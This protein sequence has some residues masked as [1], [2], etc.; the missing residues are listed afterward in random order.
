MKEV[1]ILVKVR[2]T[3]KQAFLILKQFN[4]V[5]KKNVL[6][7]YFF[8][9]KRDSLK[10]IEGK[11]TECFRLRRK[12]KVNYVTYKIDKF[13]K[14]G[15]WL[16]SEE[17][18]TEIK[19]FDTAVKIISYL[20]LKPLVEIHNCKYTYH[21][22]KYEIVLEDVKDLGLFLEVERLKVDDIEDIIKIKKEIFEF[23]VFLGID[24]EK[25]LNVGKP[26]LMLRK[27][28]KQRM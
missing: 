3:K 17:E 4:F 12:D 20:G 10:L 28:F 25:E 11:L 26:E 8:D 22:K 16:Y 5:G 7:I 27:R 19:D 18:E 6:D 21:T 15:N 14:N 9:E 1:E 23:I 2:D 24:F 13:N